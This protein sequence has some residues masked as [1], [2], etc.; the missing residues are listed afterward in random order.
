MFFVVAQWKLSVLKANISQ[1]SSTSSAYML[2][3]RTSNF[4]GATI[5]PIVLRQKHC[6]V[7]IAHHKFYSSEIRKVECK[8]ESF[9]HSH[10][11]DL[12]FTCIKYFMIKK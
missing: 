7:F 6:N 10:C 2:V 5:R 1:R 11:V 12:E 4:Q 9:V 3:L 8:R